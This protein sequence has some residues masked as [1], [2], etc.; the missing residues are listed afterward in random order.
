[1]KTQFFP[2]LNLK[3]SRHTVAAGGPLHWSEID[4]EVTAVK[5]VATIVQ[6]D[7]DGE[8]VYGTNTSRSYARGEEAW[9][10]D[11]TA[12]DDGRFTEGRSLAA[13]VLLDT[14]DPG[15]NPWPWPD[16]PTLD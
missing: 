12:E 9:W 3:N 6:E 15:T 11:V 8:P 1:M 13:G 16:E 4:P 7:G 10:C 2:E 5:V 14:D